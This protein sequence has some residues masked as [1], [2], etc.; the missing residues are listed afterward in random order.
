MTLRPQFRPCRLSLRSSSP[1]LTGCRRYEQDIQLP[2]NEVYDTLQAASEQDLSVRTRRRQYTQL[3]ASEELLYVGLRKERSEHDEEVRILSAMSTAALDVFEKENVRD[4]SY[5]ELSVA[6]SLLA[7]RMALEPRIA[8]CDALGV[9][10]VLDVFWSAKESSSK[11]HTIL[12][13]PPTHTGKVEAPGQDRGVMDVQQPR[14]FDLGRPSPSPSDSYDPFA[15][16]RSAPFFNKQGMLS[17]IPHS[18][19]PSHITL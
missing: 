13:A 6:R 17:Q 2:R 10:R 12:K 19:S 4:K 1:V 3:L 7:K 18:P 11:S 14:H 5:G 8:R 9:V 15:T 16:L